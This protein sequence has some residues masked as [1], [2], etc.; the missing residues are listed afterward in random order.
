[1]ARP[2][3]FDEQAVLDK[4][5]H[6]FWKKGY[7]DTSIQDLV[8]HLGLSRSSIY[9]TFGDKHALFLA[10]LRYYLNGPSFQTELPDFQTTNIRPFLVAFFDRLLIDC[11]QDDQQK[12]CFAINCTVELAPDNPQVNGL[13]QENMNSF[14]TGFQSI[15]QYYQKKGQISEAK[16][17]KA[18]ASFLFATVSSIRILWKTQKDIPFLQGIVDTAIDGILSK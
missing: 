14:I 7:H 18:L 4:A 17:P 1:M 11:Q 6:L 9:D 15:F 16:D 12:G 13:V 2:K 5:M 10:S 8:Q 3:A